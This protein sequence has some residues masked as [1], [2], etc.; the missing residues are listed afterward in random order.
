M[1]ENEVA[2]EIVDAAYK[3][4]TTLGPSLLESVYEATMAYELTK[5]GLHVLRQ[6]PVPVVYNNIHLGEGF[7]A[8]LLVEHKVIVE[9]KSIDAVAPVHKKQVLTYLKLAD[10]RLGLLINF[11]TD[12]IKNGIIRLVNRPED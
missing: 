7:R 4:H 8:D 2:R 10:E 9:L 6:H 3:I 5:R 1:T 11:N 12:L